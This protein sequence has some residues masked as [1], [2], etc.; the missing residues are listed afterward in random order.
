MR[1]RKPK[2]KDPYHEGQPGVRWALMKKFVISRTPGDVYLTRWRIFSTPMFGVLLHKITGPDPDQHPHDHPWEFW[3]VVLKNGYTELLT[4]WKL[5]DNRF[6]AVT[7]FRGW[8][9]FSF[10][11]M[12]RGDYHSIK[13]LHN[14][15]T[16]W[17][18]VFHG[19]R[20]SDWGFL[21]NQGST[22]LHVPWRIYLRLD[23]AP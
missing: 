17:T 9:R 5:K 1:L 8:R 22:P 13:R 18:L 20:K 10:H 3:S 16:T 2:Y 6:I 19:K 12:H 23:D 14:E 4:T 11:R 15:Q 7:K 21:V